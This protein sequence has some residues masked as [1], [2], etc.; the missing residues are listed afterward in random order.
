MNLFTYG[1]LVLA[2]VM[3]GVTGRVF[4]FKEA[5][6]RGYREFRVN[7]DAEQAAI[8]PFPDMETEGMVYFDVDDASLKR[9]DGFQGALYR[10]VEVNVEGLTGDWIEA[11]A[12]VI[13]LKNIEVLSAG[14]WD[15]EAFRQKHL[16]KYP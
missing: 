3:K 2:Q 12:Y 6:L 9:V 11:E 15:E 1:P 16:S 4:R 7:S 14:P 5:K 8:I 13:R 10:R